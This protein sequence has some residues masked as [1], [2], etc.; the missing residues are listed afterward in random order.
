MAS[1]CARGRSDWIAGENSSREAGEAVCSFYS[2]KGHS[3]RLCAASSYCSLQLA[4]FLQSSERKSPISLLLKF[5][6]SAF[7]KRRMAPKRYGREKTSSEFHL[8]YFPYTPWRCLACCFS[9]WEAA[10]ELLS[11]LCLAWLLFP[12]WMWWR[13]RCHLGHCPQALQLKAHLTKLPSLLPNIPSALLGRW[14]PS[15]PSCF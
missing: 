6:F 3:R 13:E 8:R 15:L 7:S 9:S 1:R 12:S 2:G 4:E 14:I 10:Q 11:L 5:S